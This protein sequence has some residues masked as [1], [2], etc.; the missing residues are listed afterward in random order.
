[1]LALDFL[2]ASPPLTEFLFE[3]QKPVATMESFVQRTGELLYAFR[4]DSP[5]RSAHSFPLLA[6]GSGMGKT[7]FGWEARVPIDEYLRTEGLQ[8]DLYAHVDFNGN[9]DTI[10]EDDFRVGPDACLALRL[11]AR[12][13]LHV[14][15]S[16][17]NSALKEEE[18]SLFNTRDVL[19]LLASTL[20]AS[21]EKTVSIL[22]HIDEFQLAHEECVSHGHPSFVKKMLYSVGNY[23]CQRGA[24]PASEDNV[25]LIPLLTGTTREGASLKLTQFRVKSLSLLPLSLKSSLSI[26]EQELG[27][28]P[29]LSERQ[30]HCFLLDLGIVPRYL[31]W[32]V[33][34][35]N[36]LSLDREWISPHD[37]KASIIAFASNLLSGNDF[38]IPNLVSVLG[39]N[40]SPD[41]HT[42]LNWCLSSKPVTWDTTIHELT[43]EHLAQRGNIFLA[44][45]PSGI[46]LTIWT[47]PSINS[48]RVYFTLPS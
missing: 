42:F 12:H 35:I 33:E 47:L 8:L 27:S 37:T 3:W 30:F 22:L 15:L 16:K 26:L 44:Q 29:L 31:E 7:R 11:F 48:S 25:F 20:G 24:S 9:G 34:V 36:S 32:L 19:K 45:Q 23:R 41:A 17:L 40:D 6:T 14:P 18:K 28:S 43:L 46:A 5:S 4:S 1:M 38:G 2:K 39:G 10:N 21:P 13:L